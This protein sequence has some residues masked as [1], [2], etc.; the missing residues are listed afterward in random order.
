MHIFKIKPKSKTKPEIHYECTDDGKIFSYTPKTGKLQKLKQF[1]CG[2]KKSYLCVGIASIRHYVHRVIVETFLG[3]IPK[4]KEVDHIDGN[5]HNNTLDNLRIVTAKENSENR[6][7]LN[8]QGFGVA[9]NIYTIYN[10]NTKK[11]IKTELVTK[12]VCKY[13]N[14]AESTFR[15]IIC[16][17]GGIYKDYLIIKTHSNKLSITSEKR[18][19]YEKITQK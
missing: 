5:K 2:Y 9:Y 17:K 13:L 8:K 3:K 15:S 16:Y 18:E 11:I 1:P 4:N 10:K 14:I 19:D 7:R 6:V 12:E